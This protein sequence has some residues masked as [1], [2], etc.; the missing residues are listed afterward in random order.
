MAHESWERIE[1]PKR[2]NRPSAGF[3]KLKNITEKRNRR[4]FSIPAPGSFPR[5]VRFFSFPFHNNDL[6]GFLQGRFRLLS[7]VSPKGEKTV[8]S[9]LILLNFPRNN[10]RQMHAPHPDT[11]LRCASRFPPLHCCKRLIYDMQ[12][13]YREPYSFLNPFYKPNSPEEMGLTTHFLATKTLF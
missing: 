8:L 11:P 9:G 7:N 4:A 6:S 10:H 5:I 2:A 3:G 12:P 13:S 1:G